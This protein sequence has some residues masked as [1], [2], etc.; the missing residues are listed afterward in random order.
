VLAE[1]DAIE[2]VLVEMLAFEV[3]NVVL[4]VEPR[5]EE[6]EVLVP[7]VEEKIEELMIIEL[8]D[9]VCVC[10]RTKDPEENDDRRARKAMLMR[11]YALFSL[12]KPA[13]FTP[14]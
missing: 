10:A 4:L 13:A 9:V 11:M 12:P 6:T 7:F 2:L 3:D 5:L 1:V 14:N 8:D